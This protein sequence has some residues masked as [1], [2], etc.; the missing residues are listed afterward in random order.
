MKHFS[1]FMIGALAL[2][3]WSC[4]SDEPL[5]EGGNGNGTSGDVHA[6][7]QIALPTATRSQTNEDGGSSAG[8][9]YGTSAENNVNNVLVVL[10]YNANE[11]V[12]NSTPDYRYITSAESDAT[13]ITSSTSTNPI[14]NLRFESTKLA[15][16]LKPDDGGVVS[17]SDQVYVFTYCNPTTEILSTFYTTVGDE[18]Q[19]I[20]L[21]S[22]FTDKILTISSGDDASIWT[23]N[24]FLM[25]NAYEPTAVTL[26][27][28]EELITMH[29]TEAKAFNLGTVKVERAAVRFDFKSN[30]DNIYPI[31]DI[32]TDE[33][34]GRVQMIGLSLMNEA[35]EF[36]ALRRVSADGKNQNITLGGL[37]I[38][39][40]NS[41][42]VV[43]PNADLK[44]ATGA[45][46]DLLAKYFLQEQSMNLSARNYTLISSLS[47]DDDDDN[48]N[49][50]S[51][52]PTSK[53]GFKFWRYATE[54]TIPGDASNQLKGYT[55]SVA[56]KAELLPLTT[57]T[58]D[59]AIALASAITN[60]KVI[61]VFDKV[62]YGDRTN[63]EKMCKGKDGKWLDTKLSRAYQTAFAGHLDDASYDLPSTSNGIG[64]YRPDAD[65]HYYMYYIYRVRHNDNLNN[66]VM[67]PMEFSVVRNNVYK[68][69]VSDVY[70]FGHP[71]TPDDPDPEKPDEP[72]ESPEVRF[73]VN[74]EV[75]PWVV[76]MNNV[77]FE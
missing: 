51:G 39:G 13:N 56:F 22:T 29:N 55:T 25:A 59:A 10:A 45:P 54:N 37:E 36:Y 19:E 65:G 26:P 16:Y 57:P 27:S 67:W 69:F 60:K 73:K 34:V 15:E 52:F 41:N 49:P 63:L 77:V 4:S 61:Y 47:R 71:D 50:E 8:T 3:L 2:G 74:V 11:G 12:E 68:M 18:K 24:R 17:N 53:D 62:I 48:W 38:G 70:D 14:Y 64:M 44:L 66:Q 33:Y 58:T 23:D 76:R 43:S 32:T 75:L 21:G 7:L 5:A 30:N 31:K 1:K 40:T 72:D 20:A 46:S 6:K 35:S 42:Y 9:E 28:Y